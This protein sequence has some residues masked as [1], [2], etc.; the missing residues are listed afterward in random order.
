MK[1][2]VK[3][4]LFLISLFLIAQLFNIATLSRT[5]NIHESAESGHTQIVESN[6]L[7]QPVARDDSLSFLYVLF[8]VAVGTV[9]F[10]LIVRFKKSVLWK[11][12]YFVAVYIAT[13]VVLFPWLP[14]MGLSPYIAY[15]LAF[16]VAI[17]KLEWFNPLFYNFS[18]IL[19]YAG[20]SAL[21][22]PALTLP[23]AFLL[24]FL[25][26]LYDMY[27]VWK[28]QH[29]VKMALF[30]S[31]LKL[32]SGLMIPKGEISNKGIKT[33]KVSTAVLGG[34]D[35]AFPM[36]FVGTFLKCSGNYFGSLI[37]VFFSGLALSL[38]FVFARKDKFYPAMP[39]ITIGC[40]IGYLIALL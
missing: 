31:K 40:V 6:Y 22:V 7:V 36:L 37:I 4:T 25:I 14:F 38:L 3:T 33:R 10:L 20:I 8:G 12:W 28:S 16:I 34:G 9:F 21:I 27:A 32:F 5:I 2:D 35:V 11:L 30:Q 17:L 23:S 39:F 19:V 13:S 1:H 24:L 29:M 26:S 18:E 15:T